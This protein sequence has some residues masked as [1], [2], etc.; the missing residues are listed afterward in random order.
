MLNKSLWTCVENDRT[1]TCENTKRRLNTSDKYA[2]LCWKD[3]PKETQNIILPMIHG[4]YDKNPE[5]R[6][7]EAIRSV[8]IFSQTLMLAVKSL[9]YDSCPMIGFDNK[10]L[11]E[12]INLPKDHVIGM[13]LPV[14]K[15]AQPAHPKA[16]FLPNDLIFTENKWE[17]ET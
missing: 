1:A 13:M 9:G 2:D 14:G 15:A 4:F 12:L 8:S 17:K 7:D 6:R 5:L 11:S 16:G 3:A 10:A